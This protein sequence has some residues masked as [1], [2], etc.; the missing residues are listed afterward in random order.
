MNA[1]RTTRAVR[2]ERGATLIVALIMLALITLL[3]VNA[4]TLSSSNLKAVGNMQSREE[5]MAAANQAIERVIS[6]PFYNALGTQTW[7]VDI[8]KDGTND[9]EVT[10]AKPTC[11]RAG[12]ATSAYPSDVE[13]GAAMTSGSFWNVDWDIQASV[14]DSLTGA[15]VIVHQGVRTYLSQTQKE[16]ACP[17]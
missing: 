17:A 3:V 1:V 13:L 2:R 10:T 5:T 8:N 12:Q 15:S 4:F 14:T 7:S 9:Y 16:T 6:S 11:I